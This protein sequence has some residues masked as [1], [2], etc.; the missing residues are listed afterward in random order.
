MRFSDLKKI[1]TNAYN[2]YSTLAGGTK[3]YQSTSAITA[4]TTETTATAGSLGITGHATGT[5]RLFV[6]DGT[7]WQDLSAQES[8]VYTVA[9]V[10]TAAGN[11]YTYGAAPF[12]GT[13]LA[14]VFAGVDV[15]A[16][17]DTNYIT[18][19]LVNL[20]Q[21][22][23]G[24]TAML[25]DADANTTKATGGTALAANTQRALTLH[26]TAANLLTA[27]NDRLRFNAAGTG[28]LAN[29]VTGGTL[30]LVFQRTV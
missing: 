21:A 11:N 15:L 13:L 30:T 3:L 16:A 24:S 28:T 18:F 5:G 29:T 27:A 1:F 6:S 7:Y 23:A 12:K 20:G 10:P 19:G 14:A 22:G 25:A 2:G 4:G 8:N 26:G 17:S 9:T